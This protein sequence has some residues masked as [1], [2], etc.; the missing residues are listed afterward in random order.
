MLTTRRV[1]AL[2]KASRNL[3]VMLHGLGDTMDGWGFLPSAL[4]L[5]ELNYVFVNAPDP[6]YGGFSWYDFMGN[7]GDGIRRSR[8]LLHQLLDRC[9][10][11]GFPP[12]KTILM[13]FSQG[14]VMTLDTGLRHATPLA[15]LVGISGYVHDPDTLLRERAPHAADIP[16]LV[17]HGTHD[18][19]IPIAT[20]RAQIERLQRAALPKLEWR[21]YPK[22]HTLDDGRELDDIRGFVR[23][24]LAIPTP[25]GGAAP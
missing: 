9:A 21:E 18:P 8:L 3:L 11:E 1:T 17:T 13:G 7:A 14:C 20:S 22:V 24:A 23:R 4:C 12:E 5:P 10:G 19:L 6:Y 16:V 2:Q 15:G 25:P